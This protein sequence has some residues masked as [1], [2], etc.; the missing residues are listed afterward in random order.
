MGSSSFH[1]QAYVGPTSW[2]PYAGNYSYRKF[3]NATSL[4]CPV[5]HVEPPTPSSSLYTYPS[6]SSL[7]SLS[8]GGG[9][10]DVPWWL[11]TQLVFYSLYF[12]QFWIPWVT[13][14]HCRQKLLWPQLTAA[15]FSGH[16]QLFRRDLTG[17]SCP[18]S[19]I[20]PVTPV[21]EPMIAPAKI[22]FIVPTM[23][24]FPWSRYK[25]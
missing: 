10:P 15:P 2:G 9:V 12:D 18:F 19:T 1:G 24:S 23:N 5:F 3:K 21:L 8:L 7:S 25:I 6:P 20:I 13:A 4:S 22:R 11:H 16:K 14:D 17:A